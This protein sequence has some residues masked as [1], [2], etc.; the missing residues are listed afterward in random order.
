MLYS[1][2][3]NAHCMKS[4]AGVQIYGSINCNVCYMRMPGH[5]SSGSSNYNSCTSFHAFHAYNCYTESEKKIFFVSMVSYP[6]ALVATYM[7]CVKYS[8]KGLS[9]TRGWWWKCSTLPFS[10]YFNN[11]SGKFY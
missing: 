11:K 8:V 9:E 5:N 1:C 3:S 6:H 4:Q 2:F 7:Y 10:M